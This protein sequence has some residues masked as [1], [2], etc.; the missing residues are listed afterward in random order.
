MIVLSLSLTV[1][2]LSV[3]LRPTASSSLFSLSLI[4]QF[5]RINGELPSQI[6]RLIFHLDYV[7]VNSIAP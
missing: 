6:E 7:Y 2:P 4:S 1:S 5:V 3:S